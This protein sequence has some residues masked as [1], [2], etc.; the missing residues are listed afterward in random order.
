MRLL[1]SLLMQVVFTMLKKIMLD[2][3]NKALAI[4]QDLPETEAKKSIV[5]LVNYTMKRE[6]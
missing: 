6:K 5:A 2:F 4:I 3:A 1:K